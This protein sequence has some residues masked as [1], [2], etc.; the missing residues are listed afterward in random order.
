MLVGAVAPRIR[1][2]TV[3]SPTTTAERSALLDVGALPAPEELLEL[4]DRLRRKGELSVGNVWGGAQ[5]LVVA[6]VAARSTEAVCV[7]LATDTEAEAFLADLR[8]LGAAP[9]FFPARESATTRAKEGAHADADS[10]RQR[11]EFVQRIVGPP[12]SRP[13]LVVTSVLAAIQPLPTL[14]DLEDS[15]L[16]LA[17]GDTLDTT[18]LLARLIKAGYRREPL[19][20]AAGEVSLR[21]DILDIFPWASAAPLRIEM[22]EDEVESLRTFDPEEQRSPDV[23]R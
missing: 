19:A 5:A 21:G 13:R 14:R 1:T 22:L 8:A 3:Q 12:E 23:H 10:I 18:K 7:L 6:A 11:L 4:L 17:V 16:R 2:N 9:T 15:F 20:E